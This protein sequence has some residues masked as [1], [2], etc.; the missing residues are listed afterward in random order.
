M[1]RIVNEPKH[2]FTS[3]SHHQFVQA[4][5]SKTL[6]GG[7]APHHLS[8]FIIHTAIY[9]T[10]TH[11][12]LLCTLT[13]IYSPQTCTGCDWRCGWLH[14]VYFNVKVQ[15]VSVWVSMHVGG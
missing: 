1:H 9:H 10:H 14:S 6:S 7:R 11:T 8:S 3:D 5:C 15:K 2:I 12:L 4:E 13:S